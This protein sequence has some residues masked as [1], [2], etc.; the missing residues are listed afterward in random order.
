MDMELILKILAGGTIG[1]S[2]LITIAYGVWKRMSRWID[3]RL[4]KQKKL[5]DAQIEAESAERERERSERA[6]LNELVQQQNAMIEIFRETSLRQ[7][8][9]IDGLTTETRRMNDLRQEEN[10]ARSSES[11]QLNSTLLHLSDAIGKV[12]N[13]LAANTGAVNA[14]SGKL[15]MHIEEIRTLIAGAAQRVTAMSAAFSVAN[16]NHSASDKQ[17]KD[18]LTAMNKAIKRL[19]TVIVLVTPPQPQLKRQ[20]VVTHPKP[21]GDKP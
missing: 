10:T 6:H 11:K 19:D 8:N 2:T 12:D 13:G 7:T 3:G 5:F 4:E 20:P 16:E 1:G 14:L 9:A 21:I 15:D 18:I 17:H